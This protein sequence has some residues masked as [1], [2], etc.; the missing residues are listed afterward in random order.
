V[1]TTALIVDNSLPSYS[2]LRELLEQR[3][4]R[5]EWARSGEAALAYL[6]HAIPNVIFV[7]LLMPGMSGLETVRA[8]AQH[9]VAA[10]VPVVLC[11]ALFG[12][13]DKQRAREAGA[14]DFLARPYEGDG[15]DRVLATV[16]RLLQGGQ[17]AHVAATEGARKPSAVLAVAEKAARAVAERTAREV[18]ETLARKVATEVAAEAGR[19]AA[20]DVATELAESTARAVIVPIAADATR[21]QAEAVAREV[22]AERAQVVAEAGVRAT[23]PA[24]VTETLRELGRATAEEEIQAA[25]DAMRH[26]LEKQVANQVRRLLVDFLTSLEFKKRVENA[27]QQH[28]MNLAEAAVQRVAGDAARKAAERAARETARAAAEEIA[29]Q[30]GRRAAEQAVQTTAV[31]LRSIKQTARSDRGRQMFFNLLYGVLLLGIGAYLGA[32][33]MGLL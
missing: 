11:A 13:D 21:G 22:A 3:R 2:A 33:A 7:D 4:V 28:A 23:A 10:G 17:A 16:N 8:I 25:M 5:V 19:Q 30:I 18:A 15:L 20:R 29:Q 31:A 24:I 1:I 12:Y 9:P 32:Q 6:E 14:V 27:I 26:D